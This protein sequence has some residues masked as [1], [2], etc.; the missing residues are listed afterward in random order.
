MQTEVAANLHKRLTSAELPSLA[1]KGLPERMRS[2]VFAFLGLTAA[3]GL[4]LV[5]LFAQPTFSLLT[6]APMPSDPSRANAVADAMPVAA[7]PALGDSVPAPRSSGE[8]GDGRRGADTGD[9]SGRAKRDTAVH[10]SPQTGAAGGV[11]P[12]SGAET[13]PPPPE[14]SPPP[15]QAPAAAPAPAP[16][17]AP[18]PAPA[19]E[20]APA[21]QPPGESTAPSAPSAS[22][23][24]STAVAPTRGTAGGGASKGPPAHAA[25]VAKVGSKPA[26][27]P[28]PAPSPPPAAAPAAAGGPPAH[29]A[30]GGNGSGKALGHS[31]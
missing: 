23:G 3:A 16:Q 24:R 27:A 10:G 15:V 19:P 5:A 13:A 28:A 29:S 6:P 1:G 31:K 12:P 4:A 18:A 2:T 14:S 20:A 7:H 9:A 17:P 30:A 25:S 26:P 11:S 21:P 8:G 22:P